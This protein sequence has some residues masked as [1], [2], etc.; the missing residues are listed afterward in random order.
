MATRQCS[1][2][3]LKED[4]RADVIE[5]QLAH[6]ERFPFLKGR[7]KSSFRA[8]SVQDRSAGFHSLK[9]DSRGRCGASIPSPSRLFPFLKGRFKRPRGP[10]QSYGPRRFPF[11][12]GRFKRVHEPARRLPPADGFH[13]LKEDSRGVGRGVGAP[14]RGGFPFLK[15]RFKR[16]RGHRRADV[17]C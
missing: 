1:F 14:G 15:G 4:S 16:V 13:S 7:F 17:A 9:E 10:R 3:S 2:H 8:P 6:Q 11:L 12:K 5:R